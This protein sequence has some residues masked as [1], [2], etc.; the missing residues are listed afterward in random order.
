M[1]REVVRHGT[2]QQINEAAGD[3]RLC[4]SCCARNRRDQPTTSHATRSA[5]DLRRQLANSRRRCRRRRFNRRRRRRF[6]SLFR[7]RAAALTQQPLTRSSHRNSRRLVQQAVAVVNMAAG[8]CG[9]PSTTSEP[10]QRGVW[11]GDPP[12]AQGACV[13]LARGAAVR[14]GSAIRRLM[15]GEKG[16]AAAAAVAA[17]VS[18][19]CAWSEGKKCRR[20]R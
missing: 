18:V 2:P 7:F 5:A 16:H 9:W 19:S 12:A 11:A 14:P 15:G 6:R 20:C 10:A 17:A 1:T 13:C 3:C 8:N 4:W